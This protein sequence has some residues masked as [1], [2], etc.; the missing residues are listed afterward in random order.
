[1]R[2]VITP[3]LLA[4]A[5]CPGS[6]V[7]DPQPP[8]TQRTLVLADLDGP[9]G[10]GTAV[11]EVE[12]ERATV[13][14]C[15]PGLPATPVRARLELPNDTLVEVAFDE[16]GTASVPGGAPFA[17]GRLV[18]AGTGAEP[19]LVGTLRPALA[20]AALRDTASWD[21]TR[22][23]V[24]GFAL[25]ADGTSIDYSITVAGTAGFHSAQLRADRFLEPSDSSEVPIA[26]DLS[27]GLSER[28]NH[29]EGTL[30]DLDEARLATLRDEGYMVYWALADETGGGLEGAFVLAKD[31]PATPECQVPSGA[32]CFHEVTHPS[33]GHTTVTCTF[34]MTT[35]IKDKS[36]H[37]E[38]GKVHG[39]IKKKCKANLTSQRSWCSD[40]S[41]PTPVEN[42]CVDP[43]TSLPI[44]H[45]SL[46]DMLVR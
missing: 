37:T 1:M 7:R 42:K 12:G 9:A 20:I 45:S 17:G 14:L 40:Q 27:A 21:P 46:D 6:T 18:I 43:A 44:L 38:C 26:V 5:G 23:G 28:A 36:S 24:A 39:K 4:M 13:R 11:I 33:P 35:L 22:R 19:A 16:L 30:V 34:R 2:L 15:A 29:S 10:H 32:E 8:S 41:A 25:S 31:D 3:M